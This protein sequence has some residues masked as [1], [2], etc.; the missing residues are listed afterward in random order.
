MKSRTIGS[1]S[2]STIGLGCNNFGMRLDQTRTTEVVR[3]ALDVGITFFD[4]AESYGPSEEYLGKALGTRRKDA[5]IATKFGNRGTG[6]A[7]V[8]I[9]RAVE[10]SLRRLK[11]DYIDLYQQHR[12]DPT[13]P[14]AETL[15]ALEALKKSGKVREVGCSNFTVE[16]LVGAEAQGRRGAVRFASIQNEYSLL[17]RVPE[18]D[19]VLAECE[20]QGMGF[21]P[22]FPLANGM[23]TGKYR[24]GQPKPPGTRI[25][26]LDYFKDSYNEER[27]EQ[28]ERLIKFAEERGHT[29]LELAFAWLLAKPVVSSVIAGA[30]SPAQV[31]AN[32]KAGGWVLSP[33]EVAVVDAIAPRSDLTP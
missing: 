11:T 23:L 2:V 8:N 33:D 9:R 5:V 16:M 7:A 24:K 6:A 25:T 20:R 28:V 15:E 21:L 22:Y 30:T 27:L 10:D 17:H 26:E 12:P 19:G 31:E 3:N 29:I 13:T 32:A 18:T 1:L 14:V 4:T